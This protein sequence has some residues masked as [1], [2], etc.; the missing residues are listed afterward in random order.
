[1]KICQF[2][3]ESIQDQA[4]KCRYCGEY[5]AGQGS[6]T[7]QPIWWGFEYR[8]RAELFGWPLI[9]ITSGVNPR[10]GLPRVAKGIIA[11]GNFAV[12]VFAVGGIALGGFTIAGI[13]SGI[14]V[15]AGIAIGI[16]A[17]GGIAVGVLVAMGGLAISIGYAFGGLALSFKEIFADF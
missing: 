3:A 4:V 10:T 17:A 2:C 5:L 16:F 15:L 11:I 12:G 1:M 7:F 14:F 9:H 13:G 6:I 8:S